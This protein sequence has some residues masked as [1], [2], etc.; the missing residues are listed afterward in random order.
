MWHYHDHV[1]QQ[2]HD[3]PKYPQFL[4]SSQRQILALMMMML[5]TWWRKWMMKWT[6]APGVTKLQMLLLHSYKMI[7]H[8]IHCTFITHYTWSWCMDM[9]TGHNKHMSC[10]KCTHMHLLKDFK[11]LTHDLCWSLWVRML[12]FYY[13]FKCNRLIAFKARCGETLAYLLHD[14]NA[15]KFITSINVSYLKWITFK[16][17]FYKN[18]DQW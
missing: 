5:W 10:T 6:P 9:A 2:I 8:Y 15:W 11:N 7:N 17:I 12:C 13:I 16:I 3:F 18:I 1:W 14:G 4:M